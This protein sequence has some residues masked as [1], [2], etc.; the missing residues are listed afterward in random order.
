MS[1]AMSDASP[2]GDLILNVISAKPCKCQICGSETDLRN[3]SQQLKHAGQS[4]VLWL[5]A[6][7]LCQP[8]HNATLAP[9]LRWHMSSRGG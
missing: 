3:D 6:K 1:C 7:V 8:H 4:N 5:P 9:L 2:K